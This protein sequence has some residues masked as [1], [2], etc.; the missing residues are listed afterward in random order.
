[1]ICE[2][3][4]EPNT[5]FLNP[6]AGEYWKMKSE[7]AILQPQNVREIPRR[8][9]FQLDVSVDTLHYCVWTD[10]I[11]EDR[12]YGTISEFKKALHQCKLCHPDDVHAFEQLIQTEVSPSTAPKADIR[13]FTDTANY[14]WYRLYVVAP[15]NQQAQTRTIS[16]VLESL[17]GLQGSARRK[18]ERLNQESLF[19]K[20]VTSSAIIS[21]GFN[22]S[23]GERLVSDYDV[24][25][26]WL[27][28]NSQLKDIVR[29]LQ[30]QISSPENPCQFEDFLISQNP[31][32][33]GHNQKPFY[34][35]CRLSNLSRETGD[36]RWYRIHHAFIKETRTSPACF[37]LTV[38]DIH[39]DKMRGT[40]IGRKHY[41]RPYNGNAEAMRVRASGHEMVGTREKRR[42]LFLYLFC[43]DDCRSCGRYDYA[44]RA[45]LCA[46]KSTCSG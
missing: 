40:V 9:V 5:G 22:C 46:K 21:L 13:L 31:F 12:N 33:D 7:S 20:A 6:K 36:I 44:T 4:N 8:I 10:A 28:E 37:Y 2:I 34:R 17:Q 19:R 14:V 29:F 43:G 18:H 41:I 25:P 39:E 30:N 32:T 45:R 38:I 27:P 26:P 1:M 42:I 3:R 35:D 15:E 16:G 11:N 23:T 24:L